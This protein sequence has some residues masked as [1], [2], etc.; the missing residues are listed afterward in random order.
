MSSIP[1]SL[2]IHVPWCERKC[3]YCDFNSHQVRSDFDEPSYIKA[4]LQDLDADIKQFG[5]NVTTRPVQTVF[6]GGGTPSL[7]SA[8]SYRRLF[9]GLAERLDISDDAEITLEANPGSSETEKF[10]G[11][12]KAGINRL[13]IGVQSYNQAHLKALGR[14]HDPQEAINAA[15]FAK[16]AGFDNF[17]LDLMFGLPEQSIEQAQADLKQAIRLS[18]THLSCYQLTIEPNTLFH[19]NP[20]TTP[21]DDILWDMQ[22]AL[23]EI[24]ATNE[25]QQ[26]EVSAY[27]AADRQ[28]KHN[29]NYWQFGDYL[30]IG[31]G[32]HG[33][34]SLEG[35][36][37]RSWKIKHP[38]TYIERENKIGG[39]DEIDHQQ[40]PFEY[41][42]NALR[43][44]HGISI[45]QF[46]ER[47][48][49]PI[50]VIRPLLEKHSNQDL[51]IVSDSRITP[52]KFG[53]N[54]LNIMLEDYL[55][56]KLPTS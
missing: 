48:N 25:Y 21:N 8:D 43:L 52:T 38:A 32:A 40:I 6:I 9:A 12:R 31:A 20:P 18:P 10:S 2:Y 36:I 26:Y 17:N 53:H 4:L 41:M 24:L 7:F 16:L 34:L 19:A 35:N 28:C 29:L 33:K 51:V 5:D 1:L 50:S 14:I 54:M 42:M 13:S 45:S 39:Q 46:E 49:M 30:G 15:T 55:S 22:N 11:F 23:Q 47:T 44:N 3:P 56:L 37:T 27:S